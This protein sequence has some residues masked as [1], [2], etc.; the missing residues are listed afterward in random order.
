M[1]SGVDDDHPDEL[2]ATMS[3]EL[4]APL[5]AI[6]GWVQL[7]RA[8][9]ACTA[10]VDRALEIVERNAR[11]EAKAVDEA[12]DLA[13]IAGGTL[14]VRRDELR[15][16]EALRAA[17]PMVEPAAQARG[18]RLDVSADPAARVAGDLG[19]LVQIARALIAGAIR[20]SVEGGTVS[21][22][23]ALEEDLVVLRVR[24]DRGGDATPAGARERNT[25]RHRRLALIGDGRGMSVALSRALARLHD[26]TIHEEDG[27]ATMALRLPAVTTARAPAAH[28]AA[29]RV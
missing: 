15:L 21:I 5:Q 8:R 10:E 19:R 18:V 28:T 25:A 22:R 3:H 20:R 13:R 14:E 26:G 7:I 24:E 12:I 1:S 17:M 2:L 23:L 27:G 16:A 11:L 6:L 4:R 29:L 9:G